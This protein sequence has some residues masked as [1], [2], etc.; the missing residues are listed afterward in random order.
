MKLKILCYRHVL[1]K[2]IINIG[3]K[4]DVF[5]KN[6]LKMSENEKR[7]VFK[8]IKNDLYDNLC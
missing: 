1:V 4:Q 7:V 8:M 3:K 2:Y 6:S 5:V